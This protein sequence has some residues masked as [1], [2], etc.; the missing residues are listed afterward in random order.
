MSESIVLVKRYF[1]AVAPN[2]IDIFDLCL[3]PFD[4]KKLFFS[5]SVSIGVN[6]KFIFKRQKK[7]KNQMFNANSLKFYMLALAPLEGGYDLVHST[8][9]GSYIVNNV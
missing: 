9:K 2:G 5:M 3:E 6:I 7:K 1:L 8:L 4:S